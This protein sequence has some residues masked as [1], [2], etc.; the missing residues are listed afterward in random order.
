[1]I[2]FEIDLHYFLIAYNFT[3]FLP[4]LFFFPTQDPGFDQFWYY[5]MQVKLLEKCWESIGERSCSYPYS[6]ILSKSMHSDQVKYSILTM[7]CFEIDLIFVDCSQLYRILTKFILLSSSG[8]WVWSILV[9][10]NAS[11]PIGKML[12]IYWRT[13]LIISLFVYL[14][15][16]NA[17]WPS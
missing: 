2:C 13:I 7:I 11:Q 5:I 6:C 15:E 3:K 16:F 4:S 1:M 12:G 10:H 14:I 17:F 8:A 9:L